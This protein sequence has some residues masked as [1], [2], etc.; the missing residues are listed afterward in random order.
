MKSNFEPE[1]ST[2]KTEALESLLKFYLKNAVIPRGEHCR[3]NSTHLRSEYY[4]LKIF[5]KWSTA[6]EELH[7][8]IV[9]KIKE[10]SVKEN[11]VKE[12]SVKE[13]S[14]KENSVK[15]NSVKE[16]SLISIEEAFKNTEY[17]SYEYYER[18]AFEE[19]NEYVLQNLKG[20][21]LERYRDNEI[22]MEIKVATVFDDLI[23][24]FYKSAQSAAKA[25]I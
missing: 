19:R 22:P 1:A 17:V 24:E 16:N 13:N 18:I 6:I 10:N 2:D 25:A 12:N 11:S 5:G 7:K 21:E 23:F 4:Y 14:V 20:L 9:S 3:N 8:F 15:E